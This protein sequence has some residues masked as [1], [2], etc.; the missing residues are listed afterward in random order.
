M[1]KYYHVLAPCGLCITATIPFLCLWAG[2]YQCVSITIASIAALSFGVLS[3]IGGRSTTVHPVVTTKDTDYKNP[4][5]DQA[6]DDLL[7]DQED[8]SS[9]IV[10]LTSSLQAYTDEEAYK[11]PALSVY[12]HVLPTLFESIVNYLNATS[13]PM[14][15][16]LVKI[17]TGITDFISRVREDKK[18]FETNDGSA[19]VKEGV[20]RMREHI[21]EVT[22]VNAK[23]CQEVSS[24]ILAL[25][26]Q[27]M[28]ILDI[29]AS[30]S[31]VAERIHILSINASIEAARAGTHGRGF[32]II[33]DE[34]Q[35]LSL[36]TQSFV[37][38]IGT[39]VSTTQSAFTSLHGIMERNRKD[40]ERFVFDD[41]STYQTISDSL[42][43][44]L[45]GVL[46]LYQAVLEFI[47]SLDVDMTAFAPIGML[48][49]IITQEI[50]NLGHIVD[51]LSQEGQKVV[52]CIGKNEEGA[53]SPAVKQ[54]IDMIRARLTTSREL[55]ALEESLKK[56]GLH[57]AA[58]LKRNN[59]VIEFF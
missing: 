17:K 22:Q 8:P 6:T 33:A 42:D 28:G 13:E 54:A 41:N 27:M 31:D 25:D 56:A 24:K 50:E 40:V 34:V 48:H 39:S 23:S 20:H 30:I 38:T 37:H 57:A 44:Q 26:T 12:A 5:I 46:D 2:R 52:E 18:Q 16:T 21:T 36:E 1:K 35:R 11:G 55:D 47:G 9:D 51:D 32:K 4:I 53:A 29:V 45:T 10:S 49:A 7:R 14:S 43:R 19:D 59:T 3:Y 58:D 15:E